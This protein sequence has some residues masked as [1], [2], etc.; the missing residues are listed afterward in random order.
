MTEATDAVL[1]G[2]DHQA[3]VPKPEGMFAKQAEA[4]SLAEQLA[5]DWRLPVRV[6]AETG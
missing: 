3:Q 1:P 2:C 5:G 6:N 4:M